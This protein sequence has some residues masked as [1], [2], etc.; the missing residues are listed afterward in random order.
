[1]VLG[2]GKGRQRGGDLAC[3]LRGNGGRQPAM[4]SRACWAVGRQPVA[5]SRG[6]GLRREKTARQRLRVR[7]GRRADS[8]TVTSRGSGG[9]TTRQ[10][11]RLRTRR[12]LGGRQRGDDLACVLGGRDFA[13]VLGGGDFACVLSSG[14]GRRPAAI[15]MRVG[16]RRACIAFTVEKVLHGFGGRGET[17]EER[18][19]M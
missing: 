12:R 5:T 17:K 7:A 18:L 19:A 4:T 3:V 16:R 1:M 15:H 8:A 6:A 14:E 2:G 9:N 10:R 11:P 13:C